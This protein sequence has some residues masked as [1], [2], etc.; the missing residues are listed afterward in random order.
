MSPVPRVI[1][2]TTVFAVLLFKCVRASSSLSCLD[3]NLH[4]P[5]SIS[6]SILK[7]VSFTV[8][9]VVTCVDSRF[10]I[11]SADDAN[12]STR[13]DSFSVVIA[14]LYCFR[15]LWKK[16]VWQ[17]YSQPILGRLWLSTVSLG[18][19][20]LEICHVLVCQHFHAYSNFLT[21]L[22]IG[23]FSEEGEMISLSSVIISC[24]NTEIA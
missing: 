13:L 23:F 8:A 15:N 17:L 14:N 18:F 24:S 16:C 21:E 4:C 10:A 12:C 7:P 1:I 3:S 22:V 5:F 19:L 9:T 11:W 6:V 2:W 20:L